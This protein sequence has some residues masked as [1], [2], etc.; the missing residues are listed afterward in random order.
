MLSGLPVLPVLGQ[1]AD[2]SPRVESGRIVT[3]GFDDATSSV[4]PGLRVFGYDFQEDPLDPYFAGDPGF[5]ATAGSGL[6][7]GQNLVFNV[8][9]GP[10]VSGTPGN[11]GYWNGTGDVS[12]GAVPN[13]E[14]LRLNFGAQNRVVDA[15]TAEVAGFSLGTIGAGGTLH[16][17]LNS[18]LERAGGA[19]PADGIYVFA[20][21]LT[22]Q[23]VGD[24]APFW[25]VFNN[26]LSEGQHDAAIEYVEANLVP[27]PGVLGALLMLGVMGVRRRK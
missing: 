10:A 2:I 13:G 19:N 23:G 22:A 27:E 12:L 24:S 20:M 1:H 16:R 14:T 17:H 21:E 8:L 3:D 26:G 5:N 6:P 11:L 15:S 4:L 7:E 9:S 25:I 18:F